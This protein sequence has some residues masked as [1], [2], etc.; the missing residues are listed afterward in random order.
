MK[1]FFLIFSCLLS[2]VSV[3]SQWSLTG[4]TGTAT[5]NFVGTKDNVPLIFK[6]D[7]QWAGFTGYSAKKNVS[8]G[9]LALTNALTGNGEGNTALGAQALQTNMRGSYNTATGGNALYNNSGGYDNTSTGHSALYSNTSGSNNIATG[10]NALYSNTN[11]GYNTAMGHNSLYMNMNGWS[12][13]AIGGAALYMNT[14]GTGNT[15]IGNGADVNAGNLYNVTVIGYGAI[16]TASD[17]VTIGNRYVSSI[18]G[19]VPW[20]TVSDGRVKKNIQQNVPGLDFINLLKPVTYTMDLDAADRIERAGM[21]QIEENDLFRNSPAVKEARLLQ[22][23]QIHT[24]FIAQDVEKAAKSIG[25]DFSGVDVDDSENGLYGLRYSE[26]IVPLVK[27]VQEL[28]EQKN[29]KD[30]TIVSLQHQVEI[31]T[32]L[33]NRLIENDNNFTSNSKNISVSN[34]SLEQNF[35]NP[36]NQTTTIRYTL[37]ESFQSAQIIVANMFGNKIR[38]IPV[39]NSGQKSITIEGGSLPAGMYAYSLYVDNILID[40]KKMILT[41]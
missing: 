37:P 18:R 16:A 33:V 26:F 12:N 38:Q 40:T 10:G 25:Y 21:P 4:N 2:A 3:F 14:T 5:S 24:G 32:G 34:A 31:L 15:A 17:Q 28:S 7:N 9:Y 13:T 1:K 20:T 27:A 39:Y 8:F 36:F 29:A 11:G 22:Q 19:Y 41:K 6:V 35:P 23:K 30:A